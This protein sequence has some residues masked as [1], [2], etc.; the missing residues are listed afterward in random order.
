MAIQLADRAIVVGVGR[1]P[2]LGQNGTPQHLGGPVRDATDFAHWL[3][4]QGGTNVTLVT[5]DGMGQHQW[6]IEHLRPGYGDVEHP[7]T[8]L[9][10]EGEACRNAGRPVVLGRRLTIYLAG[11][12]FTPKN[13]HLALITAEASRGRMES[14]E[15][16]SWAD[17][18]ADQTHFDEIVLLMDCCTIADYAQPSRGP[19]GLRPNRRANGPAKLVTIWATRPD[20]FAYERAG[21]DGIVR[22]VFTTELL[23]ALNGA[24]AERDGK[25][26]TAS[27]RRYF[28]SAG[29]TGA[30][31]AQTSVEEDGGP[32]F[33]DDA[34]IVFVAGKSQPRYRIH[35]GLA[36]GTPVK[37]LYA[38]TESHFDGPC[39]PDGVV[40]VELPLGLYVAVGGGERN[41]FEIGPGSAADV[42]PGQ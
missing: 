21:A 36:A 33:R 3:L 9:V 16:T 38:G 42:Y 27:L 13:K 25:V 8:D 30:G 26:T 40:E 28:R 35:T 22:G 5:S 11:H 10:D 20:Q 15:A 12:G 17:W 14:I 31:D 23:K 1:Y 6:T 41:M 24:A 7:L 37:I 32:Y 39:G 18:F 19:I 29:L 34:D 4:A 2:R